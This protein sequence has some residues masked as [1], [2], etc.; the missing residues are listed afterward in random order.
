MA[1]DTKGGSNHL[2]PVTQYYAIQEARIKADYV[3]VIVHGGHE[4]YQLPS[5]RMVR[6]FRFFIDAGA[7]AVVNHH[8]HCYSSFEYYHD[9]PIYY[10]TGNFCFDA[11]PVSVDG[12]W[13]YGYAVQLTLSQGKVSSEIF[14]YKQCSESPCVE[15]LESDSFDSKLQELKA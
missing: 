15:L 4:H 1:S 5:L 9:R 3:I 12:T 6:M 10:G 8:Q 11:N 14:P 13:N 2:D 7:D